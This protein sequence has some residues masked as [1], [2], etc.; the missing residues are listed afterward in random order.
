MLGT[1]AFWGWL[2]RNKGGHLCST[3]ADYCHETHARFPLL[4][5]VDNQK[6][7]EL[8]VK[9]YSKSYSDNFL[10]LYGSN[11]FEQNAYI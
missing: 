9:I 2:L 6:F 7:C 8:S 10:T 1:V 3:S 5:K 11:I 4:S